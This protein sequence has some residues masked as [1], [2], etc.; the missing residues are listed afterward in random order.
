MKKTLERMSISADRLSSVPKNDTDQLKKAVRERVIKP[1]EER[2]KEQRQLVNR[3][4]ARH[5]R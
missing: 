4:R 2:A 3:V 1:L 5:V